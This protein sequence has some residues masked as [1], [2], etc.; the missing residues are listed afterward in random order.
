MAATCRQA[1]V[2]ADA[3]HLLVG[4][5]EAVEVVR[6][7]DDVGE[8]A[9]QPVAAASSLKPAMTLLTTISVATPSITLMMQTSAR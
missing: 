9:V 4:V 6:L 8:E 3:G 1:T 2:A 7:D 5:V